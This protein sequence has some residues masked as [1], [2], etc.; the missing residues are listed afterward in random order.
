MAGASYDAPELQD[1]TWA[2]I[3]QAATAG[4]GV[5]RQLDGTVNWLTAAFCT[6][7]GNKPAA[8][9]SDPV[10]AGLQARLPVPA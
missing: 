10:I 9:C 4:T 1:K 8:V 6:L 3:A 7:A 2:Q 5:G